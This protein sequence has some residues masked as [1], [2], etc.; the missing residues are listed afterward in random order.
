MQIIE[1]FIL[2]IFVEEGITA[3][4]FKELNSDDLKELKKKLTFGGRIQIVK[5][6]NEMNSK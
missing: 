1:R 2:I 3:P 4:I 5:L 6:H